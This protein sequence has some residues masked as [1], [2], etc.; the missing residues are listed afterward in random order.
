MMA[1]N[2]SSHELV[3]VE[4]IHPNPYR[5]F[6]RNPIRKDQVDKISESIGRTGFW[7]NIVVRPY[8]GKDG[9]FQIAYGHNRLEAVKRAGLTEITVPVREL[10]DWDMYV[11]MVDEN[12]SQQEISPAVVF[13]NVQT[14]LEILESAFKSIGPKGTLEQFNRVVPMG[15]TPRKS[16]DGCGFEQV[17]NTFFR[18]GTI[19]RVFVEAVL[20]C[21]K[22]RA[23]TVSTV[24]NSHYGKKL[25]QARRKEEAAKRTEASAK[26]KAAQSERDFAT[27]ERLRK[28][29]KQAAEDAA[30]LEKEAKR[31]ASGTIDERI[32]LGFDT[33]RQMTA[34]AS[35]VKAAGVP[36]THHDAALEFVKEE[37][38][39]TLKM[40]EAIK[41]WWFEESG[42]GEA[43]R[44]R[45]AIK[46]REEEERI[47]REGTLTPFLEKIQDKLADVDGDI[48]LA[49]KDGAIQSYANQKHR[50]AIRRQLLSHQQTVAE[51]IAAIAEPEPTVAANGQT[52]PRMPMLT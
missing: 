17:R 33:P 9:E 48:R 10:S 31:I 45:K 51:L 1:K 22:I 24:L 2:V 38:I 32:L 52:R 40:S 18:D 46:S 35:A 34:F 42:R 50:N 20:P 12:E 29:S 26:E 16:A 4:W 13:E 47:R 6:K 3:L 44:Q 49:L 28:E 27:A 36:Q 11:I 15:T 39:G 14:G 43:V 5:N 19:G 21:G 7:D 30:K 25:E 37:D 41:D 23:E 8:P